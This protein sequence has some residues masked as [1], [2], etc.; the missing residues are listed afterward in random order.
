MS[1][2]L[3]LTAHKCNYNSYLC[4]RSAAATTERQN[5]DPEALLVLRP[6]QSSSTVCSAAHSL[7]SLPLLRLA[8]KRNFQKPLKSSTNRRG[9]AIRPLSVRVHNNSV[10][11]P[12]VTQGAGLGSGGRIIIHLNNCNSTAAAVQPILESHMIYL[13]EDSDSAAHSSGFAV[14]LIQDG[15][16]VIS[17]GNCCP[18]R[19]SHS[20][21][22]WLTG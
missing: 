19:A 4:P 7:A 9:A 2:K 15:R 13:M 20:R 12:S 14:E 10:K 3:K 22:G 5:T 6:V 16:I 8:T 11:R 1:L 21:G 17:L 18:L